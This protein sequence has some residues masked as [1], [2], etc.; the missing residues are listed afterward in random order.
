[1]LTLV[2]VLLTSHLSA[3]GYDFMSDGLCYNILSENDRTV[4]VTYYDRWKNED[5][6][7]GE[8][9]IPPKV[10]YDSKTYKV[11]S[12][13]GGAFEDCSGLTS[14]TIPN[15]VT[16]IGSYAF[17]DC[18][19]LTSVTIGNSVTAID[20]RAFYDCS[21]LTSVTIPNSVTEIGSS[22][23]SGCSGLTSVTIG[24]SVTEIGSSAFENCE[25]L[26]S[27]TIPNS[28]TSIGREAFYNCSGL[29]TV[30]I[31]NSVTSIGSRAF[32]Y[33]YG[34]TSVYCKATVPPTANNVPF[35]NSTIKGTLYVPTGCK[36][37]YE[38]V[39]PW[40]NFWN[41]EEMDYSGVDSAIADEEAMHVSVEN[42]MIN[43]SGI[44]DFD[45]VTVYDAQ[46]RAVYTG[47]EHQ[48][49][50]LAPGLY[51]VKAGSATA[52]IRL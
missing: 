6:V 32:Y 8:L 16:S 1:M 41:I 42:G 17:Y 31:P 13:G 35:G 3:Y 18:D 23:F 38:A 28:V 4:M 37:A 51:I 15:S 29:I 2:T 48:I 10:I 24:N 44:S 14:V 52:K 5:Y 45:C 36:D 26:T 7:S 47:T 46:G 49:A 20:E 25:S 9:V 21:G 11:V 19:G 39:D 33:C 43:V 27:V 22:A 40:R 30:T 34:L 50:N 12:I